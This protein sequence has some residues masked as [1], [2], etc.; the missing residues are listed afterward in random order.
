VTD[1]QRKVAFA[2]AAVVLLGIS[3]VLTLRDPGLGRRH[4]ARQQRPGGTTSIRT[5]SPP[6]SEPLES[7]GSRNISASSAP[8][9]SASPA[10]P[11]TR[12]ER[13]T[14]NAPAVAPREA[15]AA[16]AAA[17]AFLDGYLSY[18]YGHAEA[19]RIRAAAA[20]LLRELETSPP[21]VPATVARAH[22]RLISIS[23]QAAT[24]DHG[25]EVLAV[26]D[27]G[28]RRYGVPLAVDET[29]GRWVVTA[30]SG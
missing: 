16:T 30:V 12:G 29:G 3:V 7:D 13:E 4:D 20:R 22:P 6:A 11:A 10:P 24:G 19:G 9:P 5:E 1:R 28:L 23:A 27:D 2:S 14:K 15:R 21:R 8:V 26:I 17:R 25:V 18:S